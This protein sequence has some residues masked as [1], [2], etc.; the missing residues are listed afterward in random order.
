MLGE[1]SGYSEHFEGLDYGSGLA[2]ILVTII[3]RD[4]SLH[5]KRRIRFP[6]KEKILYLDIMLDLA[7]MK[8]FDLAV[9]K[10]EVAQQ[11]YED[12]PE[13]ISQL[14]I[15]DFDKHAFISDLRSW[16]DA[17]GWR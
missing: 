2:G 12:V 4:R 11:L 1:L 10:R 6:K 5:C 7:R 13:V 16:I 8:K 17:T 14:R 3:C 15:P 9:R